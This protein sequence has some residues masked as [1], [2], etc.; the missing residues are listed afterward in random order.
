[1][2]INNEFGND[3]LMINS[4]WAFWLCRFPN[5]QKSQDVNVRALIKSSFL[6]E[7]FAHRTN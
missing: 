4:C 1:M 6:V 5:R 3:Q 7:G 2:I